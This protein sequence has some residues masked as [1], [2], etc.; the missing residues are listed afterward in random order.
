MVQ[1]L[2]DLPISFFL[3]HAY[4]DLSRSYKSILSIIITL[5]LSLFILSSIFTVKDNLE[6]SLK[7]NAKTLLGGDLEIDYNRVE[8]DKLLLDKIGKFSL[9]SKIFKLTSCVHS[10]TP[11]SIAFVVAIPCTS[12]NRCSDIE[13]DEGILLKNITK[14]IRVLIFTIKNKNGDFNTF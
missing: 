7:I 12:L 6:E 8:G 11:T 5:F 3:I 9:I 1:L 13:K 14:T 10:S 4:R 2:N